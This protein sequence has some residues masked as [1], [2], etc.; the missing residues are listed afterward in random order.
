MKK[1][2]ITFVYGAY[3]SLAIEYLSAIARREGHSVSLAYHP[4][5]F[6]DTFLEIPQL[7]SLFN[8]KK[9]IIQQILEEKPDVLAFSTL[10]DTLDFDLQIAEQVKKA[11]PGIITLFGGIHATAL[12]EKLIEKQF[13]DIVC[14]GE[15]EIPFQLILRALS[16][17]RDLYGISNLY[18]KKDGKTVFQGTAPLQTD[19][20]LLPFPDKQLFYD[21]APYLKPV[22]TV[23]TSRGCLFN[24]SFCNNN[25]SR[26]IYGASYSPV[27]RRSP[28]NV[29]EELLS[30]VKR[31]KTEFVSFEDDMFITDFLWT[32]KFL[33][34]YREK[35]H[36]PYQCIGHP[37]LISDKIAVMLKESGC[38]F[39]EVGIQS[40]EKQVCRIYN[41]PYA[42]KKALNGIYALQ[43]ASV[44]FN[45][46]HIGGAPGETVEAQKKALRLYNRLR[47]NRVNY[48]FLTYY[49]G[50]ALTEM[51]LEKGWISEKNFELISEGKAA[52]Y[53]Q[54]GNVVDPEHNCLRILS[55]LISIL[56]PNLWRFVE[57]TGIYRKSP[58]IYLFSK[59]LPA[60][61]K[62]VSGHEVRGTVILNKYFHE[63]KRFW[64]WM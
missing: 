27:R 21:K 55:G 39:I 35:I 53:E 4:F 34:L 61:W 9:H 29:I 47:P 56:P 23:I 45:I 6:S 12:P 13:A 22:Y 18:L 2:K 58:V 36:L 62:I 10:T 48:F 44:N 41:R 38:R 37:A 64:K 26:K 57:K 31:W 17:G 15:G 54:E 1:L 32:E 14:R 43:K 16:E 20:D 19:L 40:L 11:A 24:C 60:L 30:A 51:A 5:L 3:E 49:P 25:V 7:A 8:E 59:Y 28:E 42:P 63:I 33:S 52:S 50:T 46:D